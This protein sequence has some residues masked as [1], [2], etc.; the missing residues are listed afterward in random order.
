[1]SDWFDDFEETPPKR[2]H[3]FV[4]TVRAATLSDALIK[5]D[6]WGKSKYDIY[7]VQYELLATD[8][9]DLIVVGIENDYTREYY[10]I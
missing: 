6:D 9:V 2:R 7:L 1:M 4:K 3:V 8:Q 5:L 10:T